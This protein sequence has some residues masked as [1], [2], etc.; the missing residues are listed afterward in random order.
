MADTVVAAQL[1]LDSSQAN[2]SVSSFKK[3]LKAAEADLLSIRKTFG[4]L[5]PQA[6]EAS[7]KVAALRDNIKDAKEVSD[8]FDPGKKFQVLGNVVRGAVG[9]FTALTGAMSLFGEQGKEVEQALLKVQSALALTEGLN[10]IADV[11][12]DFQRLNA[13]IQQS[14]IFQKANAVAT[15]IASVAMKAFGVSVNTTSIGFK[16]LK[17]AI[18][19]TGIGL[20]VIALTTLISKIG[21]WIGSTDDAE[22][23]QKRL[24]SALK[25]QQ[26][27]LNSEL[28]GIDYVT[29]ARIARA[30]IAGKTEEEITK[31]EESA[32]EERIAALLKNSKRLEKIASDKSEMDERSLEDQQAANNA[33]LDAYREYLDAINGEE[34]KSLDKQAKNAEESRKKQQEAA[35]KAA[36]LAK[37]NAQKRKEIEASALE[38]LKKLRDDNF[39]STIKDERERQVAEVDLLFQNEKKR[40]EALKLNAQLQE[41]LLT[42]L[43]IQRSTKIAEIDNKI[44]EGQAAREKEALNR[45]KDVRE[46]NLLA[47]I[48]DENERAIEKANIDYANSI[49]EIEALKVSEETKTALI[50]EAVNTRQQVLDEIDAAKKQREAELKIELDEAEL[51][52]FELKN[53]RLDQ[54]YKERYAIA[55]GNE[56]LQ[57]QL[58]EQYEKQKTALIKAQA[59]LR[60][61]TISSTLGKAADI[62]GKQTA[63]GKALAIAAATIDTYLS[64]VQAF[65]G[66]VATF[67]GPFGIAAGIVASGVAVAAGIKSIKEIVKAKVPGSAGSGAVPSTTSIAQAAPLQPNPQVSTTQLD[68]QSINAVGNAAVPVRA[69]VIESDVSSSQERITRLNRQA[70]LS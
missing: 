45:L 10:T 41:Q 30:K 66:M 60:L 47:E 63:A 58:T 65:R 1:T 31:I 26:D 55:D 35:Q 22:A 28:K 46:Q 34:L 6:L 24:N 19:A 51:S 64:A 8:L 43:G 70:R 44:A 29:K 38:T 20:L 23:A 27:L 54:W 9:G 52:E 7:K 57:F 5:S 11:S 36:D 3:E 40:I 37:A 16:A 2:Q 50:I 69:F 32:S 53:A 59:E 67:P 18:A 15:R 17:V 48:E 62:I 61:Q 12:K 13:L 49:D 25:D 4:E 42:E 14:A 39:L 56:M 21:D 33:S 68:Q